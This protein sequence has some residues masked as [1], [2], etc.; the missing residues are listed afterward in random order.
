MADFDLISTYFPESSELTES[1]LASARRRLAIYLRRMLPDI[2]IRPGTPLGDLLVTEAGYFIAAAEEGMRRF[3]SDLNLANVADGVIYD[4][5]FVQAFLK[6][7]AALSRTDVPASGI[8]RLV[9]TADQDY[10]IDR[11]ARYLFNDNAVFNLKLAHDG[12]LLLRRVGVPLDER[13]NQLPLVQI[14]PTQYAADVPVEGT[15][16]GAQVTT[17][18]TGK[19]DY[20]LYCLESITALVDF[21]PGVET[22]S[23]A[24]M[25]ARTRIA[26]HSATLTTRLGAVNFLMQEFPALKAVSPV[27]SG[28]EEAVR[29]AFNPLGIALGGMDVHVR[30]RYGAT[31]QQM[32]VRLIYHETQEGDPADW[33]VGQVEPT[34]PLLKLLSVTATG[35]AVDLGVRGEDVILFSKSKDQTLAP[36]VLAGHSPAETYW[37]AVKMPRTIGGAALL[38][39]LI[40]GGTGDSYLWF[41]LTYFTDPMIPVVYDYVTSETVA[42]AGSLVH[43][44]GFNLIDL[45]ALDVEY[46]RRPGTSVNLTQA[47][48][49]IYAYFNTLGGPEAQYA[50]GPVIDSMFYAGAASVRSILAQGKVLW[51]AADLVMDDATTSPETNVQTAIDESYVPHLIEVTS[52]ANFAPEWREAVS[53]GGTLFQAI[54]PRNTAFLVEK[55]AIGFSEIR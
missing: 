10:E 7:F 3:R 27:M 25:A 19:T 31:K 17:G 55:S 12:P 1:Q 35:S 46:V 22:E 48:N 8:I 51:T 2:D 41:T 16:P 23:L 15:M 11:R 33:F 42:P 30:S 14:S 28:D 13:V 40:D 6:N 24:S 53:G 45:T 50:D 26:S 39:P 49:E 54:G 44:R 47:Q 4:C 43:V 32:Q 52:S 34:S 36:M 20:P 9:F 38:S 29:A 18:S 21:D 5:D 37:L